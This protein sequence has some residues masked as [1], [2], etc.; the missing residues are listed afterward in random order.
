MR[1]ETHQVKSGNPYMRPYTDEEMRDAQKSLDEIK[2]DKKK[3]KGKPEG[4]GH[5]QNR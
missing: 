3:I 2:K 4:L 1:N 5:E